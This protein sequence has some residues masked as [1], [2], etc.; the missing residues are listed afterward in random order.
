MIFLNADLNTEIYMKMSDEMNNHVEEFLQ[1]KNLNSVNYCSSKLVL[2]FCKFLY[3]LKQFS[4]EWNK[5]IDIKLKKLDF[6]QSEA[7]SSLYILTFDSCFIL[8]YMN[9]MLLVK[10]TERILKIKQ[11]IYFLYK[12]KDLNSAALFLSIQI[13]HLFNSQ[14][15]LSQTHYI[16]KLLECFNMIKCNKI[17]LLIK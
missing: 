5:N 4:C 9:N 11:M 10:L 2:Q 8:L 13:K 3:D 15:K 12:I 14:I 6:C 1:L 7:D 17:H 16:K